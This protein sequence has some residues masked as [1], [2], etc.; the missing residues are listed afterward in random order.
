MPETPPAGT[1]EDPT[2]ALQNSIES[3]AWIRDQRETFMNLA[4]SNYDIMKQMM[5]E[6]S[7]ED[8]SPAKQFALQQL[9]E[10]RNRM[11]AMVTNLIKSLG[12]SARMI[13]NNMRL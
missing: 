7:A 10:E 11:I 13:I 5:N 12:E 8:L 3:E 6:L 2:Q 9:M 1:T 4:T